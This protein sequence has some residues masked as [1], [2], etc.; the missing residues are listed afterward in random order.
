MKRN[1]LRWFGC[2]ER[3]K[4]EEFVKKMYV[5]E[6]V[7]SNSRGRPL[8]R[9][10]DRVKEYMCEKEWVQTVEEDHLGDGRIG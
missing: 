6:S 9:W 10:K 5:S 2:T 4:N 1:M 3:M 7:G 8:G